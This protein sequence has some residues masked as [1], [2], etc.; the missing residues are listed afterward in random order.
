M[1]RK[2]FFKQGGRMTILSALGL[3]SVLLAYRQKIVS[4]DDCTLMPQCKNCGKF[5]QC[6]LSKAYKVKRDGK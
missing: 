3:F 1:N 2:D 4:A 5:A 6:N